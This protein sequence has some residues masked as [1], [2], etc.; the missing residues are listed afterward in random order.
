MPQCREAEASRTQLIAKNAAA[1]WASKDQIRPE[2]W[3]SVQL[4][5]AIALSGNQ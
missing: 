1:G 4:T 2:G 5:P 3:R